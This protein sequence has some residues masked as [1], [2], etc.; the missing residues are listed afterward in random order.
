MKS[1][2]ILKSLLH[3]ASLQNDVSTD[4]DWVTIQSRFEN[5]GLSFLTITLPDFSSW[6]EESLEEGQAL[7]WITKRF[8]KIPHGRSV[9]PCFLQG[10][11]KRV[12]TDTGG[13]REDADP[14]AIFY[15]RQICTFFKKSRGDCSKERNH[16][17]VSK[18]VQTDIGLP[19]SIDF[20]NI[21][22]SVAA[23]VISSLNFSDSH[24]QC[25]PKHGPG[26]TFEKKWGNEKYK[27]REFYRRWSGIFDPIDLYGVQAAYQLDQLI[28]V[29]EDQEKPCRLSLVPKTMKS[30]RLIAVEPTAMQYA[31]Q[32]I[33][34]RLI[35]SMGN[36]PLTRHIDFTDQSVNRRLAKEGSLDRRLATIDL[37][38]AS[39][40]VSIALVNRVFESDPVLLASL[41]AVRSRS[42]LLPNGD[43]LSLKKVTT[44]GSAITFPV[45][46]LVFFILALSELVRNDPRSRKNLV[47]SVHR[48]AH[49]VAV[50]GD[51]I[52]VPSGVCRA[53]IDCLES[54]GL[55]AN[56]RKT[57]SKGFFRESCGGD[58]YRGYDVTPKYLRCSP[59][60]DAPSLEEI[61][62]LVSTSNQ[63]F[64]A[65]CWHASEAIRLWIGLHQPIP[66]VLPT[67]P[68]VGWYDFRPV[69][70]F[71]RFTK[72]FVHSVRTIVVKT[73]PLPNLIDGWDA[74]L[75]HLISKGPSE[76]K[77]NITHSTPRFRSV[78]RYKWTTPY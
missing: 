23:I 48:L 50:Y 33:A 59:L 1:L 76:D 11:T 27:T 61:S 10:L 3:D 24:E 72:N 13:L 15:I 74:L 43:V 4:R 9:L 49:S 53:V 67:S 77:S 52:V 32:Y 51:D 45:E 34:S 41:L 47:A 65:G 58:Y 66:V 36:S 17:A 56:K 68:G 37:S 14:T 26:A 31:Q 40:R 57:F 64:L 44:S 62:S 73:K 70:E 69:Y 2:K 54:K 42:T 5:E 46:T 29:E 63:L 19:A 25:F 12:F 55:L 16:S 28:I 21:C 20:D 75:K 8:R 60:N 35:K 30:P 71:T 39:D 38:E 78:A 22:K 6:L 18:F 7:P